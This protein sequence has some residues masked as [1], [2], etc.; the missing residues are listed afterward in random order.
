G[1]P[2]LV[3][4]GG[5]QRR[6]GSPRRVV[7]VDALLEHLADDLERQEVVTLLVQHPTQALDVL[8]VELPVAGGGPLGLDQALALEEADLGVGDVRVLP[9][10]HG[11]HLP[12]AQVRSPRHA[13]PP[14]CPMTNTSRNLPIWICVPSRSAAKATVS[15]LSYVP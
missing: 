7:A 9:L 14:S 12:D 8:L 1:G 5:E 10:G 15:L 2:A 13:A 3:G 6:L 4:H 11:Q